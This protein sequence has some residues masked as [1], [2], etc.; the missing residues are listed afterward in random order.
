MTS[1]EGLAPAAENLDISVEQWESGITRVTIDRPR[2]RNAYRTRTA[3]ELARAVADFDHDDAQR[4][5]VIT[6]AGGAFCAGGDL[7]NAEEVEQA[8][9]AQFGHGRVMREGMHRVQRALELC[10]KP[11]IAMVRGPAVAGGL[12]LALACDLRIADSSARLGDTSG[13]V[14]LLPDEGGAWFLTRAMGSDRA[15]RMLWGSEVYDAEQALDAGLLTEVVEPDALD[16]TVLDLARQLAATAPLTT[17]VVKRMVR[18][19]GHQTL[20]QALHEA[21]FAVSLINDTA[22]VREGVTAFLEK[23]PPHF[24]G[25]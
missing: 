11:V 24:T 19:A 10:D 20:D 5:L 16:G 6:G 23:R 4:V 12:A 25:H 1:H 18:H 17:K 13:R 15:L 21:E 14:G 2:V 8:D 9:A 7:S 22:D 3:V